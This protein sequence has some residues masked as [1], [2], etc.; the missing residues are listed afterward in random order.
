MPLPSRFP[1]RSQGT[2]KLGSFNVR[3][4]NYHS[5]QQ[6]LEPGVQVPQEV[7]SACPLGVG[8]RGGVL[9]ISKVKRA[10]VIL[11]FHLLGIP[12]EARFD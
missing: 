8:A 10:C 5:L 4:I 3:K 1:T 12:K 7:F 2:Q 11:I 6:S 9:Q